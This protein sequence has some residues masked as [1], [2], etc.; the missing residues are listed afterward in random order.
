VATPTYDLRRT[1]L[2]T[3][4]KADSIPDQSD[5]VP[6][7]RFAPWKYVWWALVGGLFGTGL[8]G[9]LTI[10]LPLIVAGALLLA[11]GMKASALRNDSMRGVV[12]GP[13]APL[14]CL[15]WLNRDGPG[16]VC[17]AVDGG[18]RC[19]DQYSPWPFLAIA[20]AL[21]VA[22]VVVVGRGRLAHS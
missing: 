7:P 1:H 5:N 8:I 16:A 17:E 12:L 3:V 11:I 15:A 20:V 19:E 4:S 9:I 13:V 22:F 2:L 10:G 14:L 18:L 21:A 6:A